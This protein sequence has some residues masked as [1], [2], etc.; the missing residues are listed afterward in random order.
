MQFLDSDRVANVYFV[1]V[2]AML[3]LK[4]KLKA[5]LVA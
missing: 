2:L 3:M 5:E 4:L 1:L